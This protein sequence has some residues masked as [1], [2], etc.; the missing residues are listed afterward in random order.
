[1]FTETAVFDLLLPGDSRTL[2]QKRSYVRPILA[3]LKKFEVSAAE[4][5]FHDLYGRALIGV[6]IVA[7]EAAQVRAVID[8]CENQVAGRPEIELL[9]VKRRLYGDD[10]E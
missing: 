5:G 9:S 7:A 10:D 8:T 2:K 1:M 3:M 6:A 4:V